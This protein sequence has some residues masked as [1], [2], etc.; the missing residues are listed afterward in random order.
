MITIVSRANVYD[1]YYSA[2]PQYVVVQLTEDGA[3]K[4]LQ[5]MLQVKDAKDNA[6]E[7]FKF[8]YWHG[9][10]SCPTWFRDFTGFESFVQ[11]AG[12]STDQLCDGAVLITRNHLVVPED[13]GVEVS[14]DAN[15]VN[16]YPD[17]VLFSAYIK[18]TAIQ[19]EG[20]EITQADLQA[21][22]GG[23]DANLQ[24]QDGRHLLCLS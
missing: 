21:A 6:G 4:L 11:Q 19:V 16:V 10:P 7:L 14:T 18:H 12:S 15:T 9:W 23:R 8:V 2:G 13:D 20:E 3:R 22:V 5:R 1:E 24:G 17:S